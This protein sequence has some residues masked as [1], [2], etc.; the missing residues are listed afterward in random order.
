MAEKNRECYSLIV[1][2]PA[3]LGSPINSTQYEPH[4]HEIMKAESQEHPVRDGSKANDN[5]T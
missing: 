5:S 1:N 2:P 3:D 4:P